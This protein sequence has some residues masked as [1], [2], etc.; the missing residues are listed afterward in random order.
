MNLTE[1]KRSVANGRPVYWK[2]TGYLVVE[3]ELGQ[4]LIVHHGGSAIGLTWTDGR[5]LNGKPSE[6]FSASENPRRRYRVKKN[7]KRYGKRRAKALRRKRY[8]KRKR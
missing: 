1:I 7:A 8:G 6:F 2:N 3:D 5:T 4:W